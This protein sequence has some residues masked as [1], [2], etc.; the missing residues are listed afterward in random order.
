MERMFVEIPL[1][2]IFN[3]SNPEYMIAVV[4]PCFNEEEV[5][6]DLGG[7]FEK[8]RMDLELDVIFVNDGSTDRTGAILEGFS[9]KFE[10]VKIVNHEQNQGFAQ[11]L[12][13]GF[14]Y[15]LNGRY[16]Y[17]A[18]M[19]SDLTHPPAVLP[20]MYDETSDADLVIASR[21]VKGGGMK[22]VPKWRIMISRA[23]NLLFRLVL[24][25]KTLDAT[26]GF[27]LGRRR[28]YEQ[29]NLEADSFGIQLE[30]TVKAERHGFKIKEIPFVLANREKGKSKFRL[31]YL[32]GYIPLMLKLMVARKV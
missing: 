17:I 3:C 8:V 9:K 18:Q 2:Y 14:T 5:I 19:D 28:I 15:A 25:I 20:K 24:R 21:Y 30:L 16:E 13:D 31:R 27:R 12:K 11:S 29:V 10:W 6:E 32:L 1:K 4:V 26:S 22:D 7:L 23:G